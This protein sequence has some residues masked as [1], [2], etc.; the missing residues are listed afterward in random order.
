MLRQLAKLSDVM[1][2]GQ[3][4]PRRAAVRSAAPAWH[5]LPCAHCGS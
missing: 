4:Q 2:F 5:E 3:L 1:L